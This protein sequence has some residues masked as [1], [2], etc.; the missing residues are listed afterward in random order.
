MAKIADPVT[1]F[2]L[3]Y[4][5][6]VTVICNL[7]AGHALWLHV[8]MYSHWNSL[9]IFVLLQLL[10]LSA[11]INYCSIARSPCYSMTFLF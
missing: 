3:C 5:Q 10:V 2:H 6:I 11:V 1:K 9:V 4:A 8:I 7:Y